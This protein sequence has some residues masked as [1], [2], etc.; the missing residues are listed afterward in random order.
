M[1]AI[2]ESHVLARAIAG[3]INI[4]LSNEEISAINLSYFKRYCDTNND[5]TSDFRQLHS[6]S[7]RAVDGYQKDYEII[8]EAQVLFVSYFLKNLKGRDLAGFI[9]HTN[10]GSDDFHM[11]YDWLKR[12]F[13]D[14]VYTNLENYLNNTEA[15]KE[16]KNYYEEFMRFYELF[17]ASEYKPVEFVFEY[18]EPSLWTGGTKSNPTI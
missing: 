3:R 13:P 1:P 10:P 9:R 11:E 18:L 5:I 14:P 17:K 4:G 8:P 6:N 12:F 15:V 7:I 2:Y 16:E